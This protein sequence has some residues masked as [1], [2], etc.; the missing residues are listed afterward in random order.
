MRLFLVLIAAVVVGTLTASAAE[1]P[2]EAL[3][4]F[5]D[6]SVD[7]LIERLSDR[8]GA[9][10]G[11]PGSAPGSPGTRY[12]ANSEV[13][14]AALADR[15]A[16]VVEPLVKA[17]L[18]NPN[19]AVQRKIGGVLASIRD[20]KAT[21]PLIEAM[22]KQ[23]SAA[24]PEEQVAVVPLWQYAGDS[25]RNLPDN[26]AV[27]PLLDVLKDPCDAVRR[28]AARALQGR[29]DARLVQPL[30]QA[31]AD[32]IPE[33][34]AAAAW[35]LGYLGDAHAVDALLPVMRDADPGVRRHAAYA[36]GR[37]KDPR[38]VDLLLE[39]LKDVDPTVK[40]EAAEACGSMRI[41]QAVPALLVMLSA[42]DEQSQIG[43]AR[44]RQHP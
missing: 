3:D 38:A 44:A 43:A 6:V 2:S 29:K 17:I 33:V 16:S 30:M 19:R 1:V 21:G 31:L 22:R 37:L 10:W 26:V 12:V 28:G 11:P 24:T 8:G 20:P 25:L 15:G 5:R 39:A 27:E 35:E 4:A 40:R 18:G 14:K 32:P 42:T 9:W 34:R 13:A 23:P 7:T 36:L 41:P